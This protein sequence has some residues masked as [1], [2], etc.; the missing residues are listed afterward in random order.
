MT[1][2]EA[3]QLLDQASGKLADADALMQNGYH[4]DA[5]T[6]LSKAMDAIHS[7]IKYCDERRDGGN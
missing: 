6:E 7:V 5:A 3:Q 4:A 2:R 1:P